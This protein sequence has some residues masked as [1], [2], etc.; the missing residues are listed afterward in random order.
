L[1]VCTALVIYEDVA[2]RDAA[3]RLCDA[4]AQKFRSDLEFDITWWRF[5]YLSE[6]EI[7]RQAAQA[8]TEADFIVVS[9]H[10][11]EDLPLEVKAWFERWLSN[12]RVSE[13]ALVVLQTPVEA[14]SAV[15]DSDPYLRLV[16][17]RANLD[18]LPLSD[19]QYSGQP[20]RIAV[21]L[22][23]P[24]TLDPNRPAIR[25]NGRAGWGIND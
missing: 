22:S 14:A 6:P 19:T 9:V 2:T 12:R 17:L 23:S 15:V 1:E 5:K 13:G 4:L 18:Y 21:S 16:A 8:A 10:S 25:E 7:G 24:E 3:V 11:T 20:G